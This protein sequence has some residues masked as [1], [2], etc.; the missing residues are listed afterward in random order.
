MFIVVNKIKTK[1]K[2]K[3]VIS[4]IQNTELEFKI[5]FTIC[6]IARMQ[7]D[8]N[9]FREMFIQILKYI[10]SENICMYF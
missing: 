3:K 5:F 2:R 6:R 4:E 8:W 1:K 7:R 10:F 9:L